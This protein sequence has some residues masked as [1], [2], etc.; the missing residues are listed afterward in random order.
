MII[1]GRNGSRYAAGHL[2]NYINPPTRV[3]KL[4]IV[5]VTTIVLT[6]VVVT[7]RLITRYLIL[8]NPG[9]DDYM[10]IVALVNG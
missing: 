9:W 7:L 10:I 1:P 6:T 5:H 3:S 4:L 8:K 2:P